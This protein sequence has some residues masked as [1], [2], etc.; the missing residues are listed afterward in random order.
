MPPPVPQKRKSESEEYE[1]RVK[2]LQNPR[3]DLIEAHFKHPVPQPLKELYQNREELL[4]WRFVVDV[5]VPQEILD[6]AGDDAEFEQ[7]SV[8]RYEPIDGKTMESWGPGMENYI[9]FASDGGEGIYCIDPR[10]TD[11]EVHL[12]IMD[13]ADLIPLEVPLSEFLSASKRINH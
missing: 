13:G 12:F 5:P 2:Q 9:E 6:R 3:F 11:P 8:E 10:E 4:R 7:I 1:E